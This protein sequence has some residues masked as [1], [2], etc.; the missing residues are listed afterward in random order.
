MMG[1]DYEE[2]RVDNGHEREPP[3]DPVDHGG[4]SVGGGELIDD[5]T[6]KEDVDDGP[7]EES[8]SGWGEIRLPDGSVDGLR[9]DHGVDV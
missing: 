8:P 9:V 7:N 4:L 6:E 2:D 3:R 5:G 1:P